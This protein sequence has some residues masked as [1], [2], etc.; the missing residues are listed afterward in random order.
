MNIRKN[1]ARYIL[2]D[3]EIHSLI[4]ALSIVLIFAVTFMIY[5][6]GSLVCAIVQIFNNE[7]NIE[8]NTDI[9]TFV[10]GLVAV[11]FIAVCIYIKS[12]IT[13]KLKQWSEL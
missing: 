7:L 8:V 10:Y 13:K 11:M 2:N 9:T 3:F 6:I 1:I 12:A 4:V 5:G